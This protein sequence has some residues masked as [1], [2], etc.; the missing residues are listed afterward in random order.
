MQTYPIKKT[1]NNEKIND[2]YGGLLQIVCRLF[3]FIFQILKIGEVFKYLLYNSSFLIWNKFISRGELTT[4]G[5]GPLSFSKVCDYPIT[6]MH[7]T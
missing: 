7:E 6:Y 3:S 2:L 5:E 1:Q 4:P